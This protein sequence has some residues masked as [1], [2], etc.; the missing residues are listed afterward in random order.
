M[1]DYLSL[2]IILIF[3]ILM[4]PEFF[5][6]VARQLGKLLLCPLIV[7]RKYVQEKSQTS[8]LKLFVANN[9]NETFLQE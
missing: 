4:S 9:F 8:Y 5:M 2:N 3:T 6:D 7:E 1:F